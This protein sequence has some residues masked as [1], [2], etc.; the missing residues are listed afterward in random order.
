MTIGR[1]INSKTA[2]PQHRLRLARQKNYN[3][4]R[5]EPEKCLL[6]RSLAHQP[7]NITWPRGVEQ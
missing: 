7:A 1:T 4:L 3:R 2:N 6:A 5:N